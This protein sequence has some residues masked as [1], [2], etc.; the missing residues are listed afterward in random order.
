MC[1]CVRVCVASGT[2]GIGKQVRSG[3]LEP[4]GPGSE[5]VAIHSYFYIPSNWAAAVV[6]SVGSFMG[7]VSGRRAVSDQIETT[8]FCVCP[9]GVC[10]PWT[11]ALERG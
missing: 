5:V 4:L 9:V 10:V 2:F 11:T 1:V 8:G 7:C 6:R 3:G